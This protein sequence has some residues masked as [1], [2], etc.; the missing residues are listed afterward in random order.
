MVDL[1]QKRWE[2][3]HLFYFLDLTGFLNLLGLY[4]LN[5]FRFI[6]SPSNSP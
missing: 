4:F 3:F 6:L 5:S 1:G 2:L